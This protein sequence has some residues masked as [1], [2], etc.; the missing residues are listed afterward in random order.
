MF[1]GAFTLVCVR[2]HMNTN[3]GNSLIEESFTTVCVC[4]RARACVCVFTGLPFWCYW[5]RHQG[6]PGYSLHTPLHHQVEWQATLRTLDGNRTVVV[7]RLTKADSCRA[8][9]GDLV[10]PGSNSDRWDLMKDQVCG[11]MAWEKGGGRI[12]NEQLG[13]HL[14]FC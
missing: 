4:A 2:F 6:W 12:V 14:F 7:S 9:E 10:L 8:N 11:G 5:V 13:R 3:S 1:S